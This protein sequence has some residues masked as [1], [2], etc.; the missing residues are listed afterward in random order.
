MAVVTCQAS[1]NQNRWEATI[2]KSGRRL[3]YEVLKKEQV[4]GEVLYGRG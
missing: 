4:S 2:R 3:G 1:S